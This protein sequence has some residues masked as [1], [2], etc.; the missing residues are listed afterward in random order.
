[1]VDAL[2]TLEETQYTLEETQYIVGEGYSYFPVSVIFSDIDTIREELLE[3]QVHP[4]LLQMQPAL[5]MDILN[6]LEI[7]TRHVIQNTSI[8]RLHAKS[9]VHHDSLRGHGGADDLSGRDDAWLAP[10]GGISTLLR[11]MKQ[12]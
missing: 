8:Q 1:M 12:L 7:C 2:S 9:W 5:I 11:Q 10:V 6:K 4:T 3:Q